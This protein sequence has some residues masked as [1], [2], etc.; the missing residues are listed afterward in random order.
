M[1]MEF[2]TLQPL[3]MEESLNLGLNQSSEIQNRIQGCSHVF[4]KDLTHRKHIKHT[5][6]DH[7]NRNGCKKQT[8]YFTKGLCASFTHQSYYMR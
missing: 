3:V 2:S 4:S 8:D 6:S 1:V 7:H 5:F